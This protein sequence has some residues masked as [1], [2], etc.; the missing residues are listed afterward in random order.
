M[1]LLTEAHEDHIVCEQFS[2]RLQDLAS[3]SDAGV[4]ASAMFL[5]TFWQVHVLFEHHHLPS[6]YN[7]HFVDD[8]LPSGHTLSDQQTRSL[9]LDDVLAWTDAWSSPVKW[10]AKWSGFSR[11]HIRF[12]VGQLV[13]S[14]GGVEA[15]GHPASK[16]LE[17]DLSRID[18]RLTYRRPQ[19]EAVLRAMRH[20]VSELW[21]A[22]R[23]SSEEVVHIL[24][25][26][27]SSPKI[28]NLPNFQQRPNKK[29]LPDPPK[30]TWIKDH[31]AWLEA[32]SDDIVTSKIENDELVFADWHRITIQDLR[33]SNII[34]GFAAIGKH[35]NAFGSLDEIIA[36]LPK[37]IFTLKLK[38]L[39]DKEDIHPSRIATFDPH[40]MNSP[41]DQLLVFCPHTATELDWVQDPFRPHIYRDSQDQEMART[42]IW[43][44]G[45]PQ[46]T[47]EQAKFAQGQ[48][49][50]FSEAGRR[51]FEAAF[52]KIELAYTAWRHIAQPDDR[53]RA[54]SRT[55][56]SAS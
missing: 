15:F 56:S 38:K 54:D 33:G 35:K 39:Y 18:L 36:D 41:V 48:R 49:I 47:N 6:L 50:V 13:Q 10:I 27:Y 16:R 4:V 25:D 2:N 23:L 43:R 42:T 34:E 30:V 5:A 22:K 29:I 19:A 52:G 21:R 8:E 20:V 14:W 44:D 1:D 53:D 46:Q 40:H 55:A 28:V 24:F 12:R 7:L 51:Q 32:V 26:L 3:N 11:H 17:Q 45:L 9:V 37:I 31:D